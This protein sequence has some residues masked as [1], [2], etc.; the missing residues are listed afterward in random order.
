MIEKLKNQHEFNQVRSPIKLF[1][2]KLKSNKIDDI[3]E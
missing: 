3:D 1:L 2:S